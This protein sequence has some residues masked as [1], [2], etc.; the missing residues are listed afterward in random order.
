M[1]AEPEALY[2]P[3]LLNSIQKVDNSKVLKPLRNTEASLTAY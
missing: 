1:R 2:E 3:A